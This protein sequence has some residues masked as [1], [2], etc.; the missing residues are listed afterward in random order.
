MVFFWFSLFYFIYY[1]DEFP[2]AHEIEKQHNLCIGYRV[3][4][5]FCSKSQSGPQE[6]L[7]LFT[8]E[9][10]VWSASKK[11]KAAPAHLHVD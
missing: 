8:R 3:A 6:S 10:D 1:Y 11:Q 4:A 5:A 7:L 9:K 2:V